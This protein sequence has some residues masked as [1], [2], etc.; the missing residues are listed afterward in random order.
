MKAV[1][2]LLVVL[3]LSIA[4]FSYDRVNPGT[5]Y[6]IQ[7]TQTYNTRITF[8]VNTTYI[9]LYLNPDIVGHTQADRM[10]AQLLTAF[11]K[12]KSVRIGTNTSTTNDITYVT[13]I[14]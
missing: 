2:V 13:I 5:V 14:R 4:A 11:T 9:D 8:K 6:S 1:K 10:Y 3:G 12:G 7:V